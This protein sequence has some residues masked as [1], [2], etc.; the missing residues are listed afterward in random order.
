MMYEGK[1]KCGRQFYINS[2]TGHIT[3]LAFL[4]SASSYE[5]SMKWTKPG[6]SP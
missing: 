6:V 2:Q 5:K 4:V 3:T 1:Q